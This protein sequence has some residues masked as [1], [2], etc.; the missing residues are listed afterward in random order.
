MFLDVLF[1]ERVIVLEGLI[2]F[3]LCVYLYFCGEE[4]W[5][6]GVIFFLCFMDYLKYFI[7][8]EVEYDK[9]NKIKLFFFIFFFCEWYL[10]KEGFDM[11]FIKSESFCK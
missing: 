5:W 2:G 6:F 3:L 9:F 7:N 10:W 8:D 4:F 1:R 11:F